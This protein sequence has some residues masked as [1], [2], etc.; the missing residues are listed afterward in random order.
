MRDGEIRGHARAVER[1]SQ[2]NR[3]IFSFDSLSHFTFSPPPL[4]HFFIHLHLT[5]K[6]VI[7]SIDP[8]RTQAQRPEQTDIYKEHHLHIPHPPP[9]TN[10]K[11]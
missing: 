2:V 6:K 5:M 7:P 4:R 11:K 1:Y 10:H 9:P 8:H 3:D